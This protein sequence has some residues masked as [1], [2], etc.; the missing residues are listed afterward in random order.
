[1]EKNSFQKATKP[2]EKPGEREKSVQKITNLKK[3][4]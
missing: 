4:C 2:Q 3:K 1:M